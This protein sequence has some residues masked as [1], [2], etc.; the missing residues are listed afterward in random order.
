VKIKENI[1]R[2]VFL[3]INAVVLA[4]IAFLCLAPM[5]HTIAASFSD[6]VALSANHNLLFWPVGSPTLKGYE[7]V[8]SNSSIL[9]GYVNTLI[10][11]IGGTGLG[12]FATIIAAYIFSRKDFLPK[13]VCMLLIS[14]TMLFNGGL[15]PTYILISSLGL[16]NS[17][18]VMILPTAINVFNMIVLRTSFKEIPDSLEEAA[19]LEGAGDLYFLFRIVVPLSK[20]T[21]AVIVLFIA[22]AQWNSW[23]QASLY[24]NQRSLYPLQLILREIL[25]AGNANLTNA[26]ADVASSYSLYTM[27]IQFCTIIV[28]TVPILCIYPFLQ[29]YFTKGVMIGAIKG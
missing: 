20:A 12:I 26:S 1:S 5:V 27:L 2:K 21:I 15:I 8:L 11:V 4:L 22:V 10:Y 7:I 3:A 16:I 19:K 18:W 17:R 25:I 29:K 28:S 23:F 24:L 14:F 13:N 6:P 9:T